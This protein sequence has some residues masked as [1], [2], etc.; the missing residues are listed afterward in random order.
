MAETRKGTLKDRIVREMT[1][2]T[3]GVLDRSFDKAKGIFL[4]DKNGKVVI[5]SKELMNTDEKVLTYLI[6]KK[7]AVFA[8]YAEFDDAGTSELVNDLGIPKGTLDPAINNLKKKKRIVVS[9][10]DGRKLL[11]KI[12]DNF[13]EPMILQICKKFEKNPTNTSSKKKVK[14]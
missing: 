3:E 1:I 10:K 14:R 8:G 12:A 11:H 2:D 13:I 9:R 6:G 7:Y 5:L 4:L